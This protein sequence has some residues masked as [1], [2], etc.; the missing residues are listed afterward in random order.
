MALDVLWQ[1]RPAEPCRPLP[2]CRARGAW[3]PWGG[4]RHGCCARGLGLFHCAPAGRKP[5]R[6][7]GPA[8]HTALRPHPTSAT[9]RGARPA[10]AGSQPPAARQQMWQAGREDWKLLRVAVVELRNDVFVARLF[11][12]DPATGEVKWDC[13]CRPSDAT[14]LAMK[15]SARVGARRAAGLGW[16]GGAGGWTPPR[17]RAAYVLAHAVR[18]RAEPAAGASEPQRVAVAGIEARG[19]CVERPRGLTSPSPRPRPSPAAAPS[20]ARPSS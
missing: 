16:L 19:S 4:V 14:F 10:A 17:R 6:P 15:V 5:R 1:V 13:D 20:P 9:L 12:G 3:A 11:F 18:R 8:V 7:P 2:G